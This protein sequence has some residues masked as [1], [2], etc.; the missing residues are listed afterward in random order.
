MGVEPTFDKPA[1]ND[2]DAPR[3]IVGRLCTAGLKS[4]RGRRSAGRPL[5]RNNGYSVMTAVGRF[6]PMSR[7]VDL[8]PQS[9]SAGAASLHSVVPASSIRKTSD[10]FN[11]KIDEQAHTQR[12]LASKW[13]QDV[14]GLRDH[15]Y[16]R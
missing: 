6:A 9:T 13:V 15:R 7:V 14:N 12:K 5:I 3:A 2:E 16:L 10:R 11:Q 4:T 8:S 1:A